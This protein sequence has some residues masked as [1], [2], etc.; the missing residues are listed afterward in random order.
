VNVLLVSP[1]ENLIEKVAEHL[2]GIEKDYSEIELH[3]AFHSFH[4]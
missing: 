3:T 2:G 1:S 4:E